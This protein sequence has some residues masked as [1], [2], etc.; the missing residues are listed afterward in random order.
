MHTPK[1]K[2]INSK[3]YNNNELYPPLWLA[4][5]L[6]K[7]TLVNFKSFIY[8]LCHLL[9]KKT[10]TLNLPNQNSSLR[11]KSFKNLLIICELTY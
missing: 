8:I 4:K 7:E 10:K 11:L 2:S 6:K 1:V 5:K 3:K 9:Q